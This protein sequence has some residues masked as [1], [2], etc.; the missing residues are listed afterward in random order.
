MSTPFCSAFILAT[1]SG[2]TLK[3]TIIAFDALASI[4]S[5]SDTA[6]T[7]PWMTF[8]F[9]S[10]LDSFSSDCFTASTEP[11]TSAFTI[12]GSSFISPSLICSN[13]LS[14]VTLLYWLNSCSLASCFLCSTS[15]LASFSSATALNTSPALGTS[16]RPVISTGVEGPA[17]AI[18]LP[19]SSVM[20]LTLPTDV[21][22]IRTSP[23]LS[24][25]FCTRSV[26]TGPLP[27]SSLASITVP[28]ASLSGLAL[29]SLTSATSSIFSSRSS[30]PIPVFAE[31]GTAITSP[32]HSSTTRSCS[33]SCCFILSGSA[34][35]LSI[36]F[37][38]TI[39]ETPAAFAWFMD[40]T[41]WGMI[42]SSAA[43]TSMA[44]SVMF[45]PLALMAVKA[46]CPG[47]SRKV[48]FS[49]L[50]VT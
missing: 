39:M 48:I 29:S 24:V 27:L 40:S 49:P 22:A 32:P 7:A 45:A 35:S 1:G 33:V 23:D 6:P 36:L 34:V 26:A 4:T 41:V 9:T 16:P 18:A 3:P 31:T 19:L 17:W 43:T 11:C 12:T 13:R 15:S 47:V 50:Y 10:S 46:S 44:I 28:F 5:P 38:A 30:I 20:V 14:R 21:P 25:P 8:T 42:P 2:R 37:M